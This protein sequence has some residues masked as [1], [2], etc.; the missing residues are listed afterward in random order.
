[1]P[2]DRNRLQMNPLVLVRCHQFA[3]RFGVALLVSM[4]GTL[5]VAE[6]RAIPSASAQTI[7][8]RSQ[9]LAQVPGA[10]RTPMTA[11]LLVVDADR[12]NDT[13]GNGSEAA[14]FRSLTHALSVATGET[15]I[16]LRTG[17]YS[18][19]NG[20][21]FPIKMKPGVVIQGDPSTKGQSIVIQ[22]GGD[23]V[24]RTSARQNITILGAD[25]AALAGVTV[26]NAN[27]RGYGLWL[28]SSSPLVADNTFTVNT[29]DGISV[30][31]NG[32]P[33]IRNNE[34]ASNGANGITVYGSSTPEI[35]NNVFEN[36]GFGINV[37]EKAAPLIV[38]NQIV[39]NKDGV[40]LQE[41]TRAV[42][43]NNL[44]AENQRYGLVAIAQAQPDLGQ[45]SQPGGN[46]FRGNGRWAVS[47]AATSETVPAF[48]NQLAR[49]RV[50]GSLDYAGTVQPS[51][52]VQRTATAGN[53]SSIA[54]RIL[55]APK[56]APKPS[57]PTPPSLTIQPPGNSAPI[58]LQVP[59]PQPT[60]PVTPTPTQ[61]VP[62]ATAAASE[63]Q[64]EAEN[65][66]TPVTIPAPVAQ[67][68]PVQPKPV[69]IA[70]V[71]PKPI[72][73][74][75][76]P[77][78]APSVVIT[79]VAAPKPANADT[80]STSST[81]TERPAQPVTIKPAPALR[82]PNSRTGNSLA[83]TS[84]S[85]QSF[86]VPTS[87]SGRRNANPSLWTSPLSPYLDSSATQSRQINV[88]RTT[89]TQSKKPVDFPTPRAFANSPAIAQPPA[90]Q[91]RPAVEPSQ[92]V[93]AV[94]PRTVPTAT[95]PK[96]TPIAAA[97]P[98]QTN[99]PRANPP[100]RST[101]VPTR[102]VAASSRLQTTAPKARTSAMTVP[103]QRVSVPARTVQ[104]RTVQQV[105]AP[106]P[107]AINIPVPAPETGSVTYRPAPAIARPSSSSYPVPTRVVPSNSAVLPVPSGNIPVGNS[108]SRSS[109]AFSVPTAGS[110]PVA[111]RPTSILRYRVLVNTRTARD[112]AQ[113]RSLVPTAF[114]T[115][116]RGRSVMQAG[117][118]SRLNNAQ[119]TLQLLQSHGLQARVERF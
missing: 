69:A 45:A 100:I 70:P 119:Q 8:A 5:L 79:P 42:L 87:L 96:P 98:R 14:P 39:R 108:G 54:N 36:T 1:M 55:N 46:T 86:P 105:A 75:P 59:T 74:K 117:V 15:T 57:T 44:I 20:E 47:V 66:S 112:E 25:R 31:G 53:P 17:T 49:D 37:A 64:L 88:V 32:A 71:Q 109:S 41:Q 77:R 43:R 115:Q 58:S 29:H 106:T 52:S 118:F 33:L 62:S 95:A 91:P 26:T 2:C 89:T 114:R 3:A 68:Q 51:S 27:P 21:R 90:T 18:E 22:G 60:A 101:A 61:P 7:N 23:Y 83:T 4:V 13:S 93:V 48:G 10:A 81:A 12:G 110:L 85:A 28:E 34:F 104:P 92:R 76:S 73:P 94:A 6:E 65:P 102:R 80:T 24:S 82:V 11:N 40:V 67:P 30:V 107:A 97:P 103:T 56:P 9:Q 113:L 72:Q 38:G 116:S 111:A 99:F 16:L 50:D 35:R 19:D 63:S 84:L 78:P